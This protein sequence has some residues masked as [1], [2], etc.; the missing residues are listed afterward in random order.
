V[1]ALM[2]THITIVAVTVF[3]HR[4]QAHDT[5]DRHPGMSHFFRLLSLI[6]DRDEQIC[7]FDSLRLDTPSR[8]RL[9]TAL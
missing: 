7:L 2:L 1:A 6:P 5:H 9:E 3:L 8:D 4:H